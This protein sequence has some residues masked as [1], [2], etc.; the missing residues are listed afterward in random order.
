MNELSDMPSKLKI[1]MIGNSGSGGSCLS[2]RYTD[3]LFQPLYS[4]TYPAIFK[5]S[6]SI[7]ESNIYH[8]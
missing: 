3:G 1:I 5:P 6:E 7:L 4:A 2:Q 8:P